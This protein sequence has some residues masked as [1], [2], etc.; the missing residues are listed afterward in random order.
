MS[1]QQKADAV[2]KRIFPKRDSSK[3]CGKELCNAV[4]KSFEKCCVTEKSEKQL[5]HVLSSIFTNTF[6]EACPGSGKTEV[7]GLK[8]A[9]EFHAWK[10]R[11][12]G[13]AILTFTNNAADVIR[14]RVRQFAGIEKAAYPHFIGTMDSWL[15]GYIA[16]PFGNL[17]TGYLG[18][19]KFGQNDKSI[20]LVEDSVSD[21]WINNYRCKTR[22]YY[23]RQYNATPN[24]MPLYANMIRY[25][26]ENNCWEIKNP[27]SNSSEF[28]T[29]NGYF[30]SVAFK[31]IRSNETWL[32]LER[33]RRDFFDIKEKF[34]R[35]GFATYNDIEWICYRLLKEKDGFAQ[36]L[37]QRFPFIIVD[38]CQD[39]SWIQ[40]ENLG[41]LKLAGTTLH[42]VGDL[43]QA[44]Y[45]FKKVE[46]Q[47]VE[48]FVSH[49]SFELQKLTDNFRSYQPIVDLCQQIV[50]GNP[51]VGKKA[52]P[53]GPTCI[54]FLY[55]PGDGLSGLPNQFETYL[56]RQGIEVWKSAILA[57]GKSTVYKL[58]S[59]DKEQTNKPQ[60]QLAMAIHLWSKFD[61]Q[62]M[63]EV[64]RYFGKF[65]ST[66]YFKDD[67]PNPRRYYCPESVNSS[68]RWRLFLARVLDECLK[69]DSG[70]KDS[71]QTWTVW[72]ECVRKHFSQ[73]VKSC[74]PVLRSALP[75]KLPV[76]DALDGNSFRV[77]PKLGGKRVIDTLIAPKPQTSHIR[78]TTIHSVKGETFDAILLVS[79]PDRR[80]G[81]GG[82]WMEW[83]ADPQSEHARFAYVASSRPRKL[84]AW[85]IPRS[86]NSDENLNKISELGFCILDPSS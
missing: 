72:A 16:H 55:K 63:D 9:Y 37:S 66:K 21:G 49:H 1:H 61:F 34:W 32:T 68:I 5:E 60:V 50:R 38:E 2:I 40:L 76:I 6:L 64:L 82:F 29:D 44:I 75:D 19:K 33:M 74:L 81:K 36:K 23:L 45:E 15:H 18:Q 3:S 4:C 58:K 7:V 10:E 52:P 22:Y 8:A 46:P 53:N 83:L 39:L 13:V 80:G 54:C 56:N 85:A 31:S 59:L 47:K 69:S 70:I 77:P 25:D 41:L 30:N 65:I 27:T 84:L 35:D 48:S 42:F 71:N 78:I 67:H 43:R 51:V 86:A 28:Q 57:R 26:V 62:F 79:S 24:Y 20:R 17:I 73:I 12:C 11:H 14:K